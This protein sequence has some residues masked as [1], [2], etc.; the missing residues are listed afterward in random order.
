MSMKILITDDTKSWL[1]FHKKLIEELY[2]DLFEITMASNALEAVNIIRHNIEKPFDV[3]LTDLQMESDFEP[4]LAGEWLISQIKNIKE[5]SKTHIVIISAMYNIEHIAQQYGVEYIPKNLLVHNQ[6]IFK[7]L[8][9]KI[10]PY[11]NKI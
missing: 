5:Y 1:V 9:E 7:F 4:L 2:G 3:I 6:L 10:M 11:L 8:F